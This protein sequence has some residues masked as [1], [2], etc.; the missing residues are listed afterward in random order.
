[1]TGNDIIDRAAASI[2]SN[3][4][5][6]G[7]L[8]K[9]FTTQ[10]QDYILRLPDPE[11][12]VWRLWSMKESA[13]K[14]FN[15]QSGKRFY[16]PKLFACSILSASQGTV[17]FHDHIYN[18]STTVK[19]EYI[20]SIATDR[21][22]EFR[23]AMNDWFLIPP[24]YIKNSREFIY[25]RI[26]EHYIHHSGKPAK[27]ISFIKDRNDIPFLFCEETNAMI[28]VSVSQHGRFAAFTIN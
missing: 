24:S 28:P 11:Q 22:K 9:I 20:Y 10:E 1:M 6:N 16:S 15:R 12:M 21:N 25:N 27:G 8:E 7:F 5:R 2:E 13:Y 3:W 14:I 4:K 19:A 26:T 17:H 18:T 23:P